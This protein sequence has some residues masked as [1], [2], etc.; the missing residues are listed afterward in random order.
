MRIS[1]Q[2]PTYQPAAQLRRASSGSGGAF[3][4]QLDIASV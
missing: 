3:G 1:N 2:T 4:K